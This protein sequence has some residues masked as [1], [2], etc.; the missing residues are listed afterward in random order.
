MQ[1]HIEGFYKHL[2]IC[3]S[4]EFSVATNL[5]SNFIRPNKSDLPGIIC[6]DKQMLST[7]HHIVI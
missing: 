1:T 2:D 6:L 5:S 4:V 7:A 3:L